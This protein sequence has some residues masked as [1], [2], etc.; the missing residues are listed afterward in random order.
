MHSFEAEDDFPIAVAEEHVLGPPP[1]RHAL[2]N[3]QISIELDHLARLWLATQCHILA[4][5]RFGCYTTSTELDR[6]PYST[7]H[8]F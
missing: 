2:I 4:I 3:L 8:G 7:Y 5:L 6:V 1:N